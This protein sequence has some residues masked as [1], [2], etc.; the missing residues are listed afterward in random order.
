MRPKFTIY[1]PPYTNK[2]AG[3]WLLHYLCDRLNYLGYP[4]SLVI[5]FQG[6][7]WT[8]PE[9]TTP[10]AYQED[11]I[12]IYPEV[13]SD[14]P[15]GARKVVRYLLNGEGVLTGQK[16]NW[17]VNDFPLSFSK[18]YRNDCDILFYP[19]SNLD[20]FRNE[21]RS[22]SGYCLYVGKADYRGPLPDMEYLEITRTWP[23]TKQ[24]L[25]EVFNTRQFF[26]S[27]DSNS[28]T[29]LDAALCGCIPIFFTPNHRRGELGRFWAN[30]LSEIGIALQGMAALPEIIREYQNSFEARLDAIVSKIIHHFES[31]SSGR[32]DFSFGPLPSELQPAESPY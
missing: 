15:L 3:V 18:T 7:S 4:S 22:R 21:G 10:I 26:F 16:I 24:E 32:P 28:S 29:S 5:F 9:F 12:V 31:S 2:S 30:N 19:T 17:G 6:Q 8:N 1:V 23:E 11:S 14:N 25:A 20:L 13:I 27:C